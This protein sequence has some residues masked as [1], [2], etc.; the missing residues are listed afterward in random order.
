MLVTIATLI[1]A[2]ACIAVMLEAVGTAAALFALCIF[3][4]TRAV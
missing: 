2:L 1:G 3:V 4:A